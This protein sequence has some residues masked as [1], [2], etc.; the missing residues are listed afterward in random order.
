MMAP[1]TS[2]DSPIHASGR[3]CGIQE[4][5]L[6]RMVKRHEQVAC[7]C[8]LLEACADSLPIWPTDT[9]A[10]QLRLA[11][12]A[13]V[14]GEREGDAFIARVFRCGLQDPLAAALMR[15]VDARHTDDLVHA[16]DLISALQ[17]GPVPNGRISAE[18][19]GYMLRCFFAAGRQSMVLEEFAV[20]A[21]G[22]D[23]LTASGESLL[24]D[25]L[26]RRAS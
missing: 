4:A 22:R 21:L 10:E 24:L 2:S 18:T 1:D 9:Q 19:F 8:D 23:H 11:L 3:S 7:L 26:C 12:G 25:S 13:F 14:E 17:V 16:E 15:H 5:D 6:N 20:L